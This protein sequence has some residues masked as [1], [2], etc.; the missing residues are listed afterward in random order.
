MAR[1][2]L[3]AGALVLALIQAAAAQPGGTQQGGPPP[4]GAPQ[5]GAGPGM[6]GGGFM[7]GGD[8]DWLLLCFEV[9]VPMAKLE[10]LRPAFQTSHDARRELMQDMRNGELDR[11]QMVQE[12][13]AL[14]AELKKA[15]EGVLTP[16][17]LAA[18][19]AARNR[20]RP[21]GGRMQRPD[22]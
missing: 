2:T 18:L 13:A 16:E 6:R 10:K 4:D 15:Y 8:Q 22:R 3:L 9:K 11:E 1:K 20:M 21:E 19:E 5:M 14:Q 7:M 12:M 17:E